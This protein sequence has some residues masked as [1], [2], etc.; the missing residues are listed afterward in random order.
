M[1]LSDE[2]YPE[3]GVPT[4][5]V[6]AVTCFGLKIN[7]L[8]SHIAR[9]VFRALSVDDLAICFH[10]RSLDTIETFTAGS[11]WNTGM[12]DKE[13]FQVSNPQV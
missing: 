4:A 6:L 7:E 3:E 8:P 11:K 10:G 9:D 5:G 12:G 13:W 2:F 1:G